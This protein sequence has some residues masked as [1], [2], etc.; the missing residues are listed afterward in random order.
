ME[1]I[2][3]PD[4][5]AIVELVHDGARVLDLGCGDGELLL[6]LIASRHI[7]ARGVEI[8]ESAVRTCISN[9]LS[10]RQGNI[11][12]GLLDYPDQ[13][14]DFVILSETI[15]FLNRPVP[16]VCEML[17]VGRRAI[18]TFK[19]AGFWRYRWRMLIGRGFGPTLD[20]NEPRERAITLNDFYAL[21]KK[22]KAKVTQSIFLVDQ[23]RVLYWPE[24][25]AETA[26]FEIT[27]LP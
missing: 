17:R 13:A 3:R 22:V 5:E 16:L 25:L 23:R 8:N 4:L 21:C 18:I 19:N 9:G 7:Y 11:E 2:Y 14:F 6:R 15:A 27:R 10:V 26:V 24:L 1:A 12:E 20:S